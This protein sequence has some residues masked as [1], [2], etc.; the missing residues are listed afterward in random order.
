LWS[1]DQSVDGLAL[2]PVIAGGCASITVTVKLQLAWLCAPSAAVQVTV[3]VPTGKIDPE[4][5]EQLEST[6]AQLSLVIGW[7]VTT[8]EQEPASLFWII[9]AGQVIVGGVVSTTVK[10]VVQV[11]ALFAASFTVTVIVVTPGPTSVPATGFCVIVS[12]PAAVQLSEAV[13]LPTT[14]GTAAWQLAPADA[15]VPA[16]QVT[17]GGVVST[18]ATVAV[19]VDWLFATSLTVIVTVALPLTRVPAAGD[20]VIL[21]DEQLSV[22]TISPVRLG[23]AA[24]QFA[25]PDRVLFVAQVVITGGML[26]ITVIVW[27]ALELC[28]AL[29]AAVYTRVM[30]NG[31]AGEPAPPLFD[32]VTVT[33]GVPQLSEAVAWDAL[34]AGTALAHW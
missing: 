4:A 12:E 27:V 29:S 15:V 18:T 32:S 20:W 7:N 24:W 33:V 9:L 8:A 2:A 21:T 10:V 31:L 28:P 1:T 16:G 14:L 26:S 19:Q 34:A 5:G 23:M 22:A 6:T 25:F 30:I 17:I 13:T 11:A 3:V